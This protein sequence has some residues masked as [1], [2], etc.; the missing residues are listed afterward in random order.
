M[1]RRAAKKKTPAKKP[2]QPA[3]LA[4]QTETADPGL[5]RVFLLPLSS[6]GG[7]RITEES[8]LSLAAAWCCFK[9]I[10]E[11]IACFPWDVVRKRPGGGRDVLGIDD[12]TTSG[13][14]A[15]LLDMQAN[16]ETTAFSWRETTL[17]HALLWG[18]GYSEIERDGAGR[19]LWLWQLTPDR[20]RLERDE[21]GRLVLR[22]HNQGQD[23]TYL[24]YADV[25]HVKGPSHD[26][27]TGYQVVN[28]LARVLARG[29]NLDQF[30]SDFWAN[31][32][33]P[34][35][36]LQLQ[37]RL[38]DTALQNLRESWE[39]IHKGPK[40][41]RKLAI[42][43]EGAEY[44][45]IASPN[46][47]AQ[48]TEEQQLVIED[49]CRIF[50]VYPH[51]VMHLLR[52]TFNN[53]EE[54]ERAHVTDTLVPWVTRLET[55]ANIKLFGRQNRGSV[56]TKMNLKARLRGNTEKQTLHYQQMLDRGVYSVNDVL[57]LE[58]RNPIGAVG[59]KRAVQSNMTT[60]EKLGTEPVQPAAGAARPSANGKPKPSEPAQQKSEM[61]QERLKAAQVPVLADACARVLRR[62]D[63]A[64]TDALKKHAG[65]LDQWLEA[66]A[67]AHLDYAR[68]ALAPAWVALGELADADPAAQGSLFDAELA[69]YQAGL[70]ARVAGL[71]SPDT[72][73]PCPDPEAWAA[74]LADR[75]LAL[76]GAS[77]P[78]V[79]TRTVL[80]DAQGR[81]SAVREE[82]PC[83]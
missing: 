81:I 13:R 11:D 66:F 33:T 35:G 17:G 73:Q 29:I 44:K 77:A 1:A 43:E 57:E 31:D 18:D 41:R 62:E 25:F 56:F 23:P 24:D 3:A 9:V 52:A 8:A 64:T 58:D 80:R 38:R 39:R 32:S 68:E 4:P 79:V 46:D 71:S 70:Q 75:V 49:V 51:K 74:Q 37:G 19:P 72:I 10:T 55:E 5:F 60:L 15:W 22:V 14:V 2:K 83:S 63:H 53:I 36:V 21:R 42:L 6:T 27:L 50:R 59:D 16:P 76:A 78:R 34:G 47:Q 7:I 30:I 20:C 65:K 12:P 82:G 67:P 45:A 54:M 40:N 69:R 61:A 28:L 48:M 26:G